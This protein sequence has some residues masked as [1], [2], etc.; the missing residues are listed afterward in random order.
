MPPAGISAAVMHI[1][2]EALS[3]LSLVV[4]KAAVPCMLICCPQCGSASCRCKMQ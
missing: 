3:L 4:A 1:L 2:V